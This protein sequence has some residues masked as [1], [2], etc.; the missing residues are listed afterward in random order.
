M[1]AIPMLQYS[2]SIDLSSGLLVCKF[3]SA[4]CLSFGNSCGVIV[5]D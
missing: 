1:G 4:D 3:E 2:L 5:A